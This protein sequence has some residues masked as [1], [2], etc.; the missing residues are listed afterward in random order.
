MYRW[1]LDFYHGFLVVMA[2][3]KRLEAFL[4]SAVAKGFISDRRPAPG[5][6]FRVE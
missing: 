2:Q 4:N 6:L 5:R 1:L 3:G